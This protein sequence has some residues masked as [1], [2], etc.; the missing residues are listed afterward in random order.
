MFSIKKFN[1][2]SDFNYTISYKEKTEST[3]NDALKKIAEN[4]YKNN[5][6]FI[7]D[8]QTHGRGR[9]NRKWH[10]TPTSH[11]AFSLIITP[12]INYKKSGLI[13]LMAGVSI[14][15]GLRNLTKINFELKWPN[16]IIYNNK[17]IGGILIETKKNN[18]NSVYVIGIGININEKISNFPLQLQSNITSLYM[19][20]KKRYENEVVLINILNMIQRN[21][22][23]INSI[24]S[25]WISYCSHIDKIISFNTD[26]NKI[27]GQ[28][29]GITQNGHAVVNINERNHIFSNGEL[30]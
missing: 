11:L 26:N 28:F 6:L 30:L 25:K 16:D 9:Q 8:Q 29:M 12:H 3:N 5:M 24:H 23:N 13:S 1:T 14:I 27:T 15:E 22:L 20:T 2:L 7:T 18:S 4:N 21:L 10:A 19:L 17:K